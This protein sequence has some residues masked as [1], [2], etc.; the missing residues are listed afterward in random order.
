MG[1]IMKRRFLFMFL[2]IASIFLFT[3]CPQDIESLPDEEV[4]S[5]EIISF[6]LPTFATAE[7]SRGG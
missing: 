1:F 5:D 6:Y 7:I 2:I 3:S 4:D